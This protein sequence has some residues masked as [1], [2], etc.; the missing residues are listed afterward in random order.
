MCVVTHEHSHFCLSG[1][2]ECFE[3]ECIDCGFAEKIDFYL[4][5]SFVPEKLKGEYVRLFYCCCLGKEN[6]Y[7]V[8][9]VVAYKEHFSV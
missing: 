7:L 3:P 2:R 4:L 9:F 8:I 5:I 6:N 1:T